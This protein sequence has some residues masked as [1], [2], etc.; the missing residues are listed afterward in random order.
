MD[1]A[2]TVNINDKEY[3]GKVFYNATQDSNMTMAFVGHIHIF[4]GEK[5]L[6]F[7]SLD[8]KPVTEIIYKED[9]GLKTAEEIMDEVM[10]VAEAKITDV[11]KAQIVEQE[12]IRQEL[13]TLGLY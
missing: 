13:A 9:G 1:R 8:K 6:W 3:Q 2:L 10:P 7:D 5:L 4:D 11:V 12:R